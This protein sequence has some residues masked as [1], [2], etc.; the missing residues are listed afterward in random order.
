MFKNSGSGVLG[1]D[2]VFSVQCSLYIPQLWGAARGCV[3]NFG[4]LASNKPNTASPKYN[5]DISLLIYNESSLI[6]SFFS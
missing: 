2:A 5:D 6:F 1:V 4:T 3:L